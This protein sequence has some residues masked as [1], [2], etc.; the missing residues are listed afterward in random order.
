VA[1]CGG[2]GYGG[3]GGSKSKSSSSTAPAGHN[4]LAVGK[5][6]VGQAVVDGSGRTLYLF[7]RDT[8][9]KSN[10]SGACAKQWPPATL[11]GTSTSGPG[12]DRHKFGSIMRSDGSRQLTYGGH[13][14]YTFAGDSS[15]GDAKG[16][17]SKAFGAEWYALSPSGKPIESESKSGGSSGGSGG[18]SSS[19]Y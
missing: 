12:I 14:L 4:A 9:T 10:C 17:G 16:Q 19:G 1:G 7:E 6:D 2:G 8:A 13:P 15:P 11:G 3:G 5:T 18:G